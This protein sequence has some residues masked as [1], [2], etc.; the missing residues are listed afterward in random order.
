MRRYREDLGPVGQD[1]PDESL[2][3]ALLV[4]GLLIVLV[5][6]LPWLLAPAGAGYPS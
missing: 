4:F 3:A 1:E 6:V 2:I 5:F